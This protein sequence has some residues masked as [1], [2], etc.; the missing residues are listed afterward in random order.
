MEPNKELVEFNRAA[1]ERGMS[2]GELQQLET[3]GKLKP[4]IRHEAKKENNKRKTS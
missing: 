4:I 3:M 2:Y 1:R